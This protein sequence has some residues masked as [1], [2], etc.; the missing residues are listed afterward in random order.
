METEFIYWRHPTPAGIKVEEVCGAEQYPQKVWVDMALQIWSENGKDGYRD[1]DHFP[2]GAPFIDG[3]QCRISISHADHFLAV[4]TLPRT[5][6][7]DLEKFSPRTAMGIDAEKADRKQVLKIRTK[8]L[9]DKELEMIAED[10][11]E[12]NI[13]AWTIK[14]AT[15]KA[16]LTEGLDFRNAIS[17]EKLPQLKEIAGFEKDNSSLGQATLHMPDGSS[18][19][20]LLC[21]WTSE[22]CIV[23][24]AYSPKCAR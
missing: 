13:L 22:G 11:V 5:P 12:Q 15:Y 3:E 7:V 4:A 2:S 17:I 20:M 9:S 16:A 1:I 24:L 23:T 19:P 10:D 8:F 18:Y 6:E 21:S 14:E